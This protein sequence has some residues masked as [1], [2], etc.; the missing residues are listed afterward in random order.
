MT[1]TRLDASV[2]PEVA[3]I[4]AALGTVE[5]LTP[6]PSNPDAMTDGAAWPIWANTVWTGGKLCR[7]PVS[8][9]DVVVI[10]PAGY[11]PETVQIAGGL[12][13]LVYAALR[14]LGPVE[15]AEPVMVVASDGGAS[16]PAIRFR[17]TT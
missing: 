10:L 5:G 1:A 8:T 6:Y 15:V 14:P 2:I 17:I 4:V 13:D 9:Y 11:A 12:R 3:A 16:M 7:A